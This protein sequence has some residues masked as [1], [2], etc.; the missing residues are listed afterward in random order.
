[1]SRVTS[2]SSTGTVSI[3]DTAGN[4]LTSTS[5]AL[6]VNIVA[7]PANNINVIAVYNEVSAVASGIETTVATYINNNV[8]TNF[9]VRIETSGTN[10]AEYRLYRNASIIDKKYSEFTQLNTVFEYSTADTSAPGLK[11]ATSD[12]FYLKVIHNRPN[13][14]NFNA[15][16]LVL[17]VT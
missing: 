4:P 8:T 13:V 12:T 3:Q 2:S 6:D 16:L 7:A 17:E 9:L 11:T 1:M 15:K 14:G 5:G 10:I